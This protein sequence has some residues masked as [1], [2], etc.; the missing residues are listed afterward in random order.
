MLHAAIAQPVVA[1]IQDLQVRQVADPR[2]GNRLELVRV[3]LHFN[4]SS[5]V[6]QDRPDPLVSDLVFAE[7]EG[8]DVLEGGE[9][10]D[11]LVGDALIGQ[12]DFLGL[13]GDGDV[14]DADDCDGAA[15]PDLGGDCPRLQLYL[16]LE[17]DVVDGPL[18][19]AVGLR[20]LLGVEEEGGVELGLAGQLVLVLLVFLAVEFYL[21][22]GEG[23]VPAAASAGAE[24]PEGQVRPAAGTP[25]SPR[26]R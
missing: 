1:E 24:S 14:L 25:P 5:Q 17:G 11:V 18:Q 3:Q 6:A 8:A 10:G 21:L 13:L 12:V 16:Q 26:R 7:E 15:G 9:L 2:E 22:L 20:E 23:G 4:Y 19:L